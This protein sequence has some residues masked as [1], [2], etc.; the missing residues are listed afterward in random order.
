[1]SEAYWI[2]GFDGR[3][4]LNA[5]A[6]YNMAAAFHELLQRA[7]V[8]QGWV[9]Q[10]HWITGPDGWASTPGADK[11]AS[12]P[13]SPRA[14][15]SGFPESTP[16]FQWP[17]QP[18]FEHSLLHSCS[19]V[20][21]M[22]E[23]QVILAGQAGGGGSL[24][25]I[26]MA[27]PRAIGRY[28]ILPQARLAARLVVSPPYRTEVLPSLRARL[29]ADGYEPDSIEWLALANLPD[30]D[31]YG[32]LESFPHAERVAME[33]DFDG[34]IPRLNGLV[35]ALVESGAERGLLVS[36]VPGAPVLATLVE[37]R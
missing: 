36:A 30:T 29:E 6:Q 9:Q 7:G 15:D 32:D 31:I 33:A 5:P 22:E 25:A 26:C 2:A 24:S 13:V 20:L 28:N 16:F 35:Q 21:M 8:R 34:A 27:S 3:A 14:A 23:A 12:A 19:R 1:M 4:G 17:C 18:Q 10:V 11:S 37:R